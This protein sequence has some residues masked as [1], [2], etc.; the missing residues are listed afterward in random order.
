[1]NRS[2]YTVYNYLI[3]QVQV[4]AAAYQSIFFLLQTSVS[5]ATVQLQVQ[6]FVMLLGLFR[7]FTCCVYLGARIVKT[8]KQE[9][10]VAKLIKLALSLILLQTRFEMAN[11]S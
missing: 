7:V 4:L 9:Q 10:L 5:S 3:G 2:S 6:A 1:V 11:L 8:V